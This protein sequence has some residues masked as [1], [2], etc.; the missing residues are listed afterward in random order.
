MV[1][2]NIFD[3]PI[4]LLGQKYMVMNIFGFELKLRLALT[5]VIFLRFGDI[6]L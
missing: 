3:E 5:T 2:F 1:N 6:F 4:N